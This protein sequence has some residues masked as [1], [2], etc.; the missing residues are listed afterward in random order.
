MRRLDPDLGADSFDRATHGN[1]GLHL[2]AL[3]PRDRL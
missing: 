2:A 1:P 3:V